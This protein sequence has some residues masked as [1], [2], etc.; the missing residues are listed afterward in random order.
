VQVQEPSVAALLDICPPLSSQ[1]PASD[2]HVGRIDYQLGIDE[3]APTEI[4]LP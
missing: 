3:G 4:G 2:R 1:E